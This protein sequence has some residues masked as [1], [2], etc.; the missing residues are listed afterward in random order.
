MKLIAAIIVCL[1]LSSTPLCLYIYFGIGTTRV[2]SF[3]YE[4]DNIQKDTFVYIPPKQSGINITGKP[5]NTSN[6][7]NKEYANKI[8][9][10]NY[11]NLSDHNVQEFVIVTAS[12]KQHFPY[13]INTIATVQRNL[14][15]H[16]IFFYDI[17]PNENQT[18]NAEV[19]LLCNVHYRR[20]N[21]SQYPDHVQTLLMYCWKPLII[22]EMLIEYSGVW[23]MDSSARLRTNDFSSLYKDI[24]KSQGV[25][26]LAS[27]VHSNF[28]V[29]H[30]SMYSYL[31]T[32]TEKMISTT[33]REASVI[34]SY[35]T[36]AVI[37]NFIRWWVLCALEKSCMAP[38]D[39]VICYNVG[40][41]RNVYLDCHR[42][43]QAALNI[44]LLNFFGF[45]DSIFYYSASTVVH[46]AKRI[47]SGEVPDKC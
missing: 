25:K 23:W 10:S 6:Y 12:D 8:L 29:I 43:D 17:E 27:T 24:I 22:Y 7:F 15:N 11:I 38:T 16:K 31:P 20:F 36:Q 13:A 9:E 34:I 21:F 39:K 26:T 45:D 37:E 19:S 28:A 1:V 40:R 46:I 30:Q 33:Q 42:Y 47:L 2:T 5:F 4:L 41:P 18:L 32:S 44:L 14:P 3:V 35:R